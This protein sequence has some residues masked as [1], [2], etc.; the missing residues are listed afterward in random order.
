MKVTT[1]LHLFARPLSC[2]TFSCRSGIIRACFKHGKPVFSEKPVAETVE[3]TMA[4]CKESM[5]TGVPLFCGFNRRSDSQFIDLKRRVD[6]GVVGRTM[7][8]KVGRW[9]RF[10]MC[11]S[12][13]IILF[14][15]H[16][17]RF[18]H[19]LPARVH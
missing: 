19:Q 12:F 8:I 17:P 11:Y 13:F 7:M 16:K 4:V 18:S 9:N 10:L 15:E 1:L 2:L 6:E 14:S 3:R 5:E